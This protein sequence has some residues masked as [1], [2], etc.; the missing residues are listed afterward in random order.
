MQI[1]TRHLSFLL[2]TAQL[3]GLAAILAYNVRPDATDAPQQAA[4][5][6]M[7]NPFVLADLGGRT[8]TRRAAQITIEIRFVRRM[9]SCSTVFAT[10]SDGVNRSA[11]G[12]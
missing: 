4:N 5:Q 2:I 7:D 9:E 10:L 11:S 1:I 8:L 12:V 6:R 3:V